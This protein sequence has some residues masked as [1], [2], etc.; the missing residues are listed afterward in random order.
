MN[1]NFAIIPVNRWKVDK[2]SKMIE[3]VM[4]VDKVKISKENYIIIGKKENIIFDVNS[5]MIKG[6][7][8]GEDIQREKEVVKK[9]IKKI[10]NGKI[11]FHFYGEKNN[12]DFGKV[13][14]V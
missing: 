10:D 3:S 6:K 11:Y 2:T 1:N 12:I 14:Q 9:I 8:L 4:Q 13:R 7:I 5:K